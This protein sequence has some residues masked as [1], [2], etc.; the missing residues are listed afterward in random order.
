MIKAP[1]RIHLACENCE[2]LSQSKT[3]GLNDSPVHVLLAYDQCATPKTN[4]CNKP[5]LKKPLSSVKNGRRICE[6]CEICPSEIGSV[7]ITAKKH[8]SVYY[9]SICMGCAFY[10]S[11]LRYSTQGKTE[12]F[13]DC[14]TVGGD[15]GNGTVK[16]KNTRKYE[17]KFLE[18]F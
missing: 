6:I 18:M 4:D 10:A 1:K 8:P 15:V 9:E 7:M 16:V 2:R 12:I 14:E 3:N 11:E 5:T 17:S 13:F